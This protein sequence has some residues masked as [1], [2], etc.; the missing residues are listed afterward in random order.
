MQGIL[1][2]MTYI[3][4]LGVTALYLNPIFESPSNHKYDTTDFFH[5]DDN[6]GTLADFQA[7]TANAQG[8]EIVLDG[9]FNHSS[10]DSIYF[11]RY[12]RWNPTT[13]DPRRPLPDTCRTG[14]KR[15]QW[16]M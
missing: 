4:N 1:D 9:V 8:L 14:N 13:S 10:S 15:A 6:F 5:I 12:D 7:L 3:D 2:E 11:D 16:R